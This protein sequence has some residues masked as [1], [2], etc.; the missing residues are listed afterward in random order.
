MQRVSKM[1]IG[2][3]ILVL[4]AAFVCE[5]IDSSLGMLYGTILS[6]VLIIAGFDPLL[7]IPS[8]LFSQA[9]GG[10]VASIGHHRLKNVDFSIEKDLVRRLSDL[11]YVEVFRRGTSKDLKVVFIV[12]CIGILA[13]ITA[14][15]TAICIPKI[16][17]KTYIGVLV[18]VMGIILLSRARFNFSWWKIF[19]LGILSAFN[20]GISG[21]GFG[22]VV[23]AGQLISGREGKRS[24]GAT[25]LSEAPICITGFL[26]Y[27]IRNGLSRWDFALILTAGAIGGAMIGPH[28]TAKVKSERK[29]RQGLGIL[30]TLLGIWTLAKTWLIR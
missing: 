24:I 4:F 6:P 18:L 22:P 20:K 16:V 28:I 11:G 1:D 7:V 15:L 2:K 3:L 30:V 26:T 14:A 10:F 29:L 19:G 21:G 9:I 5:L 23:T 25:A 8:I 27:L 13:T 17:L 12:T